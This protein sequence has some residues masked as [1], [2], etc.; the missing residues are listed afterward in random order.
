MKKFVKYIGLLLL[1]SV[2]ALAACKK[3]WSVASGKYY[4]EGDD[5]V[6][7]EIVDSNKLYFVNYDF[8]EVEAVLKANAP[9]P[10]W[11]DTDWDNTDIASHINPDIL[12]SMGA[13]ETYFHINFSYTG[14]LGYVFRFNYSEKDKT[15][16]FGDEIFK[17]K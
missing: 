13:G 8:T 6:Y 11:D 7:I 5:S 12:K 10:D 1:L 17:L 2:F 9:G 3:D 14:D 4:L 15:I 16:T